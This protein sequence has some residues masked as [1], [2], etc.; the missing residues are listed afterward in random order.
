VLWAA[1]CAAV[2]VAIAP[3]NK[4]GT[5]PT[6][7]QLQLQLYKHTCLWQLLPCPLLLADNV[8]CWESFVLCIIYAAV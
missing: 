6:C 5:L 2:S 8:A 1:P 4:G 3:I 7:L